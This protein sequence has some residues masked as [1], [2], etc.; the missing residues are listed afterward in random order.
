MI[1]EWNQFE[2]VRR[3]KKLRFYYRTFI[4]LAEELANTFELAKGKCFFSTERIL[5]S[6]ENRHYFLL[7][8]LRILY[9]KYA[10]KMVKIDRRGYKQHVRILCLTSERVYII[11]KKKP[12]PKEALLFNDILGISCTTRR[13]GFICL[14]TRET[15]DDRVK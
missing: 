11:T 15:R 10:T 2:Y 1:F 7:R 4:S 5:V 14:H 13:D 8:S 3:K 9:L 6:N 12:Y